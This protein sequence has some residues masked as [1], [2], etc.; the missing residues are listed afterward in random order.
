MTYKEFVDKFKELH[1]SFIKT[2]VLVAF[3]E[4]VIL[5][6]IASVDAHFPGVLLGGK[7]LQGRSE[8]S[9]PYNWFIWHVQTWD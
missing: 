2:Q 4:E 5:L 1:D 8:G 3:E 9:N 6:F 7:N